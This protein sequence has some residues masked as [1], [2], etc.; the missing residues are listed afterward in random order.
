MLSVNGDMSR[1]KFQYNRLFEI[2]ETET[3][4]YVMTVWNNGVI[5]C[6]T[7]CPQGFDGFIRGVKTTYRL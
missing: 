6:K 4:Y 3:N 2:I 5:I 7:D 1:S